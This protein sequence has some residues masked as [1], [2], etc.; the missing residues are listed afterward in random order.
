M[1][2]SKAPD[3]VQSLDHEPP[4]RRSRSQTRSPPRRRFRSRSPP[5][6][7]HQ[8]SSSDDGHSS[9]E[10]HK[11]RKR[12]IIHL[13]KKHNDREKIPPIDSHT[14]FSS[15]ILRI[16]PPIHFIKP[17]DMKYDGSTDPHV[18]LRYF[19]NRMVC[20]GAIDEIKCRA[21]PVTLTGLASK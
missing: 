17:T 8:H 6:Q 2:N 12:R 7:R 10:E 11:G 16:Q 9:S 3:D 19:E 20:D 4:R 1:R 18:H 14:P 21:S 15:R 13:Y 5:R